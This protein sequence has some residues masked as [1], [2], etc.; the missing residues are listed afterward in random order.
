MLSDSPPEKDLEWTDTGIK[1]AFKYLNKL[2]ELVENNL[3]ILK[4]KN[5]Q[6]K[7]DSD[8]EFMSSINKTIK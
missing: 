7:L 2:W 4:D 6:K 3:N 8:N 5:N 1:G